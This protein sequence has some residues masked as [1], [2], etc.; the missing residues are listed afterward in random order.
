MPTSSAVN[1]DHDR[2]PAELALLLGCTTALLEY[3]R[4]PERVRLYTLLKLPKRSGR[5]HRIVFKPS[6]DVDTVLKGFAGQLEAYCRGRKGGYPHA[7]VHGFSP[8]KSTKT[9]AAPHC[10]AR[11]L[12]R[13]DLRRFFPSI[14]RQRVEWVLQ[15][16]GVALGTIPYLS[17]LVTVPEFLA[18]GLPTSPLVSNLVAVQLDRDL[19][20]LAETLGCTYTRYADDMTFSST[21][22]DRLPAEG[23]V[24]KVVIHNGFTLAAEKTRRS[25]LGQA[26]FVTGLSVQLAGRPTVPKSVKRRLRQEVY[27]SGKFGLED[28]AK[29]TD[30]SVQRLVNRVEGRLNYVCS[31]E[32]QPWVQLRSHWRSLLDRDRMYPNYPRAS[33]KPPGFASLYIDESNV[34]VDGREY[35]C[36]A[37]AEVGLNVL[38][39]GV[40]PRLP[41]GSW[42]SMREDL[43]RIAR[44]YAADPYT[45][46]RKDHLPSKGLHHADDPMDLQTRAVE[47]I[48][49]LPVEFYLAIKVRG[50]G[51]YERDYLDLVAALLRGRL[52][53][54]N[55]DRIE[56]VAEDNSSVGQQRLEEAA[57][58]LL[59]PSS[60]GVV[61]ISTASKSQEPLLA[62]ADYALGIFLAQRKG[63]DIYLRRFGRLRH[64][65]RYI[66]N[67]T[68]RIR[69]NKRRPIRSFSD[70]FPPTS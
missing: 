19:T 44:T 18:E 3:F 35:L 69:F 8:G 22:R 12:L 57:L 4:S 43:R 52:A 20:A 41:Q 17:G 59:P 66:T 56:I 54:R 65:Y 26:H 29:R 38:L 24:E 62:I 36:M 68:A 23:D 2:D 10:G 55:R 33:Y 16:V 45:S 13:L 58:A 5:G 25:I 14:T 21:D 27:Y 42:D 49:T 50:D 32:G 39:P 67:L 51:E 9:N 60:P 48:A 11:C 1:L 7:N 61:T 53:A 64:R 34:N 28:H 70:A 37:V 31:V 40:G 46:G 6:R 30:V 47:A 63:D 15:D